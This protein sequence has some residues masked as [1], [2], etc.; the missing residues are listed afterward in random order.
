MSNVTKCDTKGEHNYG[1]LK[2]P[3]HTWHL[4][5]CVQ[6]FDGTCP[7]VLLEVVVPGGSSM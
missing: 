2:T 5:D 3:K 6:V 1:T 7:L 4:K